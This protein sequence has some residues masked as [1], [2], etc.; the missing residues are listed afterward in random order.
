[1][2]RARNRAID[3]MGDRFDIRAFHD[4]LLGSGSVPMGTM[5]RIVD[6]WANGG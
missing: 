4:T 6:D 3:T 2:F 1:M 5:H